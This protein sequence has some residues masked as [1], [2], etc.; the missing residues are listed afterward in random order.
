MEPGRESLAGLCLAVLTEAGRVLFGGNLHAVVPGRVYRSSQMSADKLAQVVHAYDIR[1]VINLRGCCDPFPWYLEE[2][3]TTH[4]L[5]VA[6]EDICLSAGRLPSVY[7]MRRLLEVLDR[8]EYPILIH[9]RRGADRTG[10]VSAV[11]L[12]LESRVSLA[13]ARRQ[14]GLRYGHLA[15]GRPA[16]LDR[17]FDLYDEWLR[18]QR[19]SHSHA[20]FRRWVEHDYCPGECRCELEPVDW[21][22]DIR[23]GEPAPLRV[24][25][26]NTGIKSWRLRPGT[27][28]GIHAGFG[29]WDS[30]GRCVANG[31]AGL[32]DAEVAPGQS[33]DLTLVVPALHKPG[34]HRL[35]VDMVDEQHCWFYQTGS[36]PLE[37]ELEVGERGGVSPLM[38]R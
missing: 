27:N 32:L 35:L 6:Q 1:T 30:D 25:V 12:L 16:N 26:R 13:E 9:C 10:L 24:R 38:R 11:V 29:L 2:C 3:R 22:P 15:L 20:A 8:T 37:L 31:R 7:E 36:E 23:C 18:D 4:R 14:L 28:A 5:Q 33:I 19:L 34:R 21:P 17:Y